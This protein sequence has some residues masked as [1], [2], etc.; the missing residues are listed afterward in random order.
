MYLSSADFF[1]LFFN[2][3]N[4]KSLWN[5]IT[6][7]NG[8]DPDQDRVQTVC[9]G[10]KQTILVDIELNNKKLSSCEVQYLY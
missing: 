6:V 10:Y 3:I 1:V 8:M 5:T 9:K 4:K 7:S 2:K